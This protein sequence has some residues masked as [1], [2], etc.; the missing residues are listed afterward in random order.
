MRKRR[1]N[2]EQLIAS[3]CRASVLLT[4]RFRSQ[5]GAASAS[6]TPYSQSLIASR[7]KEGANMPSLHYNPHAPGEL[8]RI[9]LRRVGDRQVY[10]KPRVS[11]VKPTGPMLAARQ[12]FREATAYSTGVFRNPARRAPFAAR[13]AVTSSPC[14]LG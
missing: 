4:P 1:K 8:A 12:E 5:D 14:W 2:P 9:I 3:S 13:A 11:P 7:G 10:V 6:Q